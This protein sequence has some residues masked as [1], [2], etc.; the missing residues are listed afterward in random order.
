[1]SFGTPTH[2]ISP[3][4]AAAL[5][6]AP[7][8]PQ[9]GGG[10]EKAKKATNNFVAEASGGPNRGNRKGAGARR[11]N[12]NALRHG[13]RSAAHRERRAELRNLLANARALRARMLALARTLR[14]AY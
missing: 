10:R 13:M 14:A 1:M 9:G 12:S 4:I 5:S 6:R 8:M 2:P 7:R 11:G 3:V